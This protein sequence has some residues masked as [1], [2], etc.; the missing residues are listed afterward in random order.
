MPLALDIL[1]DI[2]RNSV[3]D[4]EELAREQH[5]ILQEIGAALDTPEDR[6]YDLFAEAAYPGQPIG[7]TILGTA[8]TVKAV[9]L[10]DARRPISTATIAARRW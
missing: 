1:S 7:R 3:F 10:A 8:E 9:G 2:L 6:V 5:V 4:A